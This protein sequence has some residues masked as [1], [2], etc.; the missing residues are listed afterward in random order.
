[1]PIIEIRK[2]KKENK[3]FIYSTGEKIH[4]VN[5]D[6]KTKL[7][8]SSGKFKSKIYASIKKQ[9]DRHSNLLVEKESQYKIVQEEFTTKLLKRFFDE[10]FKKTVIGRNIFFE[11]YDEF[12]AYKIKNKEWSEATIK[13]YKNIK[14]LLENFEKHKKFKLTFHNINDNFHA[15]F[16]SYCMDDLN[17]INNTYARNLGLFKTF[18]FWSFSNK[19]TYN[20]AFI[21][22]VK[23][24]KVIT[25]QIAL[26]L[27]DLQSLMSFE[28]ASSRLEKVRDVFVFACVTGLRF[29]ELSLIKKSN[30]SEKGK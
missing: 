13:R 4:P 17:H 23:P 19:Y 16:K 27:N 15:E 3:K 24:K 21:G 26:T 30:V 1:M 25:N 18:M 5:W 10:E 8:I 12:T 2:P 22:F 11:A 28:F 29:G 9:L 6:F 14:N 7:P 20:D